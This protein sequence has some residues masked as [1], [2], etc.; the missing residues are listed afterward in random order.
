MLTACIDNPTGYGRIIR[1]GEFVEEIVEEYDANLR[2][3]QICE[4]NAGVYCFSSK[5]LFEF[6]KKIKADNAK[7]EM[8][9]TDVIGIIKR[10]GKTIKAVKANSKEIIGVDNKS[11][12]LK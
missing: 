1:N 7:K 9:I 4:I 3:K 6:L 2:Q 11:V 5:G 10:K 8:Y 12:S